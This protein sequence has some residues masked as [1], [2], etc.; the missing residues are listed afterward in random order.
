LTALHPGQ[1]AARG[2]HVFHGESTMTRLDAVPVTGASRATRARDSPCRF[3]LCA[4]WLA[5]SVPVSAQAQ[6]Q[7]QA[8]TAG[9][10]VRPDQHSQRNPT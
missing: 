4:L 2:G 8:T 9:R 7:A 6:A 5:L 1:P 3:R 10:A